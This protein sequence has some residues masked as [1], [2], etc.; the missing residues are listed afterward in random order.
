MNI[1]FLT[2][3]RFESIHAHSIYTDL[4]RTFLKNGHTVYTVS[5][6]EKRRNKPTA[7]FKEGNYGNLSV[8]TGNLTKCGLIEKGISTVR[9]SS[10]YRKAIKKY[11][12]DVPFDLIMYSTPPI[13]LDGVVSKLKKKTGAKT[14]LLLKDIFPQNAVDI[15]M[16]STSGAKGVL[17]RRFRRQEKNL[18]AISDHIGCMSQANVDYLLKHNPE[19]P[20]EK[21]EVSPNSIEV[22]DFA[23]S[24]DGRKKLREQYGIPLG[25][26]VFVY[27]GN[28]GKPQ[29][30]PFLSECIRAE[31]DN[32]DIFFM[33]VG[34]GTEYPA[35]EKLLRE[36]H[37]ENVRLHPSMPNDEY[38]KM[39]AA[40]DVGMIFLDYRFTIPNFPN[41]LLTYMQAELPVIACTD[42]NSDVGAIITENGFGW[43]CNSNSVDDF[44][45]AVKDALGSDLNAMGKKG[46]KYLTENYTVEKQYDGIMRSIKKRETS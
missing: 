28:F 5:A 22:R 21:V 38:C 34:S 10:Q 18:Y 20:R 15:G 25:K 27:G 3:G 30:I 43:R 32:K 29:G 13:T 24:P 41:R 39:L 35:L 33:L 40:C 7:F 37:I 9:I 11:L 36:E 42:P 26:K 44:V 19:I 16:M 8:K 6:K 14:Y 4:L 46:R 12:S 2:I 1:L 45:N 17:Y 31:K 23:A